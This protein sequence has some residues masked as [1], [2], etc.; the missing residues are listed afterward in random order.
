M[1]CYPSPAE[2]AQDCV[3]I[4]DEAEC[5]GAV[6]GIGSVA[7]TAAAVACLHYGVAAVIATSLPPDPPPPAEELLEESDI[8][9]GP[10]TPAV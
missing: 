2:W 8:S 10:S 9:S 5:L 1:N 4:M 3:E 7:A 6:G